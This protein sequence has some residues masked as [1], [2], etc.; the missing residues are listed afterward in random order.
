MSLIKQ[1]RVEKRTTEEFEVMLKGLTLE[2]IL[3]L[4]LELENE[5]FSN[6]LGGYKILFAIQD[7]IKCGLVKFAL[8]LRRT[9]NGA[10]RFL[11]T[12]IDTLER[13]MFKYK[14]PVK[15]RNKEKI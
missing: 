4:R 5:S 1:L 8:D 10:A 3:L 9:K 15:N 2:E 11:G 12:D 6:K 14:I 7:V 13:N